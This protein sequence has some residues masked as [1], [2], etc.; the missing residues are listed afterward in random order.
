MHVLLWAKRWLLPRL[1]HPPQA[2][3]CN[4]CLFSHSSDSLAR[5]VGKA[6]GGRGRGGC[7][8]GHWKMDEGEGGRGC[9]LRR[10]GQAG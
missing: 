3:G 1:Q 9:S 7:G 4:G 2:A 10:K 5:P 6:G 8:G